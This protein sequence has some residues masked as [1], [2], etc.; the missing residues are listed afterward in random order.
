MT[1]IQIQRSDFGSQASLFGQG[2]GWLVMAETAKGEVFL[3][4]QVFDQ[5]TAEKLAG[6]VASTRAIDLDHWTLWR[7]IYGSEAFQAEEAEAAIYAESLRRGMISEADV[8]ET[9]MAL[10]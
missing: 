5:K 9:I 1:Q 3:H 2:A 4:N 6:L 8:P 10:L 7:T